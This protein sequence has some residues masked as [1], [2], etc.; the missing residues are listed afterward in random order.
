MKALRIVSILFV[1]AGATFAIPRAGQACDNTLACS[2]LQNDSTNSG[3]AAFYGLG[4]HGG[5]GLFG[6]VSDSVGGRGVGGQSNSGAGVFGTTSAGSQ[7]GVYGT[8]S[9]TATTAIGV[10]GTSPLGDGVYGTTGGGFPAAAVHAV[11]TGTGGNNW[12]MIAFSTNTTASGGV[13]GEGASMGVQGYARSTNGSGI[14]GVSSGAGGHAIDAICNSRARRE[15]GSL[16]ISPEAS[17]SLR[18]PVAAAATSRSPPDRPSSPVA[19]CGRPRPMSESR[20]T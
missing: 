13:Y 6:A 1:S 16:E 9:S 5:Y 12:A 20:R 2:F 19:E 3:S 11:N 15:P 4:T 10:E 18:A 17:R 14:S 8:S 7:A